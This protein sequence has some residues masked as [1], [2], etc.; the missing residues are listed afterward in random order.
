MISVFISI[1]ISLKEFMVNSYPIFLDINKFVLNRKYYPDIGS[2]W[3]FGQGGSYDFYDNQLGTIVIHN[4]T[5]LNAGNI[6]IPFGSEYY[7]AH[8]DV[9]MITSQSFNETLKKYNTPG[10]IIEGRK[11][12]SFEDAGRMLQNQQIKNYYLEP[13]LQTW[14]G[15]RWGS[16]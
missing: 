13:N 2:I 6:D 8:S 12:I 16:S 9:P 11:V 10:S 7:Q 1:F 14:N 3:L 4:G 15:D 5:P